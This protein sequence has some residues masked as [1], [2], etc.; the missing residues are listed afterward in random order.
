MGEKK[1]P[2]SAYKVHVKRHAI[3]FFLIVSRTITH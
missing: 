1:T 2:I 3:V